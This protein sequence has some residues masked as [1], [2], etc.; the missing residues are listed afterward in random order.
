VRRGEVRILTSR[1]TSRE[2]PALIVSNDALNEAE[3][4]SWVTA[5]R[6]DS[7]GISGESLVTVRIT[8]PVS[9]VVHLEEI[10]A[11]RKE[12]VGKLVGRVAPEVMEQVGVA[13]RAALDL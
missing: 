8:E 2:R 3:S 9:G 4:V 10:S 11:V 5:A 7:E 13:L 12:R 1:V 6:I